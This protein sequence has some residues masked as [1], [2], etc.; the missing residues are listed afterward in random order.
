MEETLLPNIIFEGNINVFAWKGVY[1]TANSPF[2]AAR[3]HNR[4]LT[5]KELNHNY[6]LDKKR[7]NF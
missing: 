5:D 6:I 1:A 4:I 2:Y 7:F 3:I